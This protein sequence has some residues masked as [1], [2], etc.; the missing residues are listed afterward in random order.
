[1][2]GRVGREEKKGGRVGGR[3][4]EKGK[5]EGKEKKEERLVFRSL[6]VTQFLP[7]L[8]RCWLSRDITT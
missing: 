7:Q 1:M 4:E 3:E 5:K 6:P 8:C 2:G